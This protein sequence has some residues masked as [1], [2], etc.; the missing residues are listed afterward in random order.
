[1][2]S[3]FIS[4]ASHEFRTPLSVI[5]GFANLLKR[6]EEFGFDRATEVEYLDVIDT[7]IQTLTQ[8]IDNMLSVSRIESGQVRVHPQAVDVT[9]TIRRMIALMEV[10]TA[11]RSIVVTLVGPETLMVR[12]DPQ[13]VEQVLLNL[14]SNAIKYSDDGTAVAVHATCLGGMALVAVSDHGVG[15]D[16]DQMPRLFEMF[17]RLDNRR[18]VEAGG[19][20][21]GLYI[22]RNWVEANGGA[23]WA[24]SKAGQGST[25]SFT[26]PLLDDAES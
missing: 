13:H 9:A 4:M 22:A 23:L 7:Q 3:Q 12:A 21:L 11:A 8:L 19:T 5:K 17:A 2:K 20:G 15:I 14:M 1:M 24:E 6:R 16:A 26:L 10:Q 25:F 18:T